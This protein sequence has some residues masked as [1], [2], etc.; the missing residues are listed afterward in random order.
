M[1]NHT[2][3]YPK[4]CREW[5]FKQRTA[6]RGVKIEAT[7]RWLLD[8]QATWGKGDV[9][10][11]RDQWCIGIG[12]HDINEQTA[13]A[14]DQSLPAPAGSC[15]QKTP[16]LATLPSGSPAAL[17]ASVIKAAERWKN[18]SISCSLFLLLL[19]FLSL[20]LFFAF[21]CWE[22][23]LTFYS[24]VVERKIWLQTYHG[25]SKAKAGRNKKGFTALNAANT[26]I[27]IGEVCSVVYP[28]RS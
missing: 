23:H 10:H 21:T 4:G 1:G 13:L 15:W 17:T 20:F 26:L 11:S 2:A 18:L 6:K 3:C 8:Q 5:C 25:P 14:F 12:N 9:A 27:R 7:N 22:M 28:E 16:G 19:F 24:L